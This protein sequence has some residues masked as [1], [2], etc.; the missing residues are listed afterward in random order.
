MKGKPV[1]LVGLIAGLVATLVAVAGW[2][3]LR[4]K[5]EREIILPGRVRAG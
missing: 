5:M 4:I 1:I 2:I 3:V